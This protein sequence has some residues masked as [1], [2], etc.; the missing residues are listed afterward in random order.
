MALLL[1]DILKTVKFTVT[2]ACGNS[3]EWDFSQPRLV[4]KNCGLNYNPNGEEKPSQE[5]ANKAILRGVILNEK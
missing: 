2:C 3:I 4:C 1:G 5:N